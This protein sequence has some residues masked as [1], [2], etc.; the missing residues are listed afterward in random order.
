[1]SLEKEGSVNFTMGGGDNR[2]DLVVQGHFNAENEQVH[3]ESLGLTIANL[4][5]I[6]EATTGSNGGSLADY[7][8]GDQV[9][10]ISEQDQKLCSTMVA[11]LKS[12]NVKETRI[13]EVVDRWYLTREELPDINSDLGVMNYEQSLEAMSILS[14]IPLIKK[15]DR[16]SQKVLDFV[17][18][19]TIKMDVFYG[20][21]PLG[22]NDAGKLIVA[23]PSAE[24]ISVASAKIPLPIAPMLLSAH[25]ILRLYR[26]FFSNTLSEFNN[27]VSNV[28]IKSD[29]NSARLILMTLIKH[30][31]YNNV[32]DI[33]LFKSV[34]RYGN[35]QI[36]INDVS[37]LLK[38]VPEWLYDSMVNILITDNNKDT[39]I[40]SKHCSGVMK[41]YDNDI[42]IVGAEIV[43]NFNFRVQMGNTSN[44]SNNR[45]KTAVIRLL[46]KSAQTISL[47]ALGYNEKSIHELTDISEASAGLFLVVGPTGSGKSTTLYSLMSQIDPIERSIVTIE[48]PIE[49]EHGAWKQYTLLHGET[50]NTEGNAY[51]EILKSLLRQA[52]KI[53]LVGEIRDYDVAY[54][55]AQAANT[56]HMVYA[57]LHANSAA[58]GIARLISMGL[59]RE[60]LSLILK[61]VLAQRLVRVLCNNCKEEDHEHHEH[62]LEHAP[63]NLS[64]EVKVYKASKNGCPTCQNT[65]YSGRRIVHEILVADHDIKQMIADGDNAIHIED[66]ALKAKGKA[67]LKEDAYRL[68]AMGVTS[69]DEIKRAVL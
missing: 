57:T 11:I 56:G 7:I 10:S 25:D 42:K 30:C 20:F 39:E 63:N 58:A 52:P 65:G 47:P 68:V 16:P 38:T 1:M 37:S 59:P 4:H 3:E 2:S 21:V 15:A 28:V 34:A 18:N 51:A 14:G 32:S 44:Q 36:T 23:V 19:G 8:K 45:G 67:T 49:Y 60:D 5:K 55:A 43:S 69:L 54:V 6:H 50:S 41:F 31:A 13:Q 26:K 9:E 24:V 66:A 12:F 29:E 22:F 53:I 64:G 35:I 33:H 62:V 27:L 46:P 40:T 48:N 17:K 61:G